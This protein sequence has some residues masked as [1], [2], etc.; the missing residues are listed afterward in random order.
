MTAS[1]TPASDVRTEATAQ[2]SPPHTDATTQPS[3][4]HTDATTQPSPPHTDATTQ[5]A[6]SHTDTTAQPWPPVLVPAD[7]PRRPGAGP[8]LSAVESAPLPGSTVNDTPLDDTPLDGTPPDGTLPDD[9]LLAAAFAALLHRYTGQGLIAVAA[10]DGELRY[11]VDGEHTLADLVAHGTAVDATGTAAA[12]F[13]AGD[14]P[15]EDG[16]PLELQLVIRAGTAQLRYDAELFERDTAARLLGHYLTLLADALAAPGRPV[17]ALR[18]LSD[19]ELHTTLVEWNRTGTEL[20]NS[21]CLHEAFA[22]RAA[23]APDAVAVVHAGR[24]WTYG[25]VNAAANRLAHHLRT[26]GVG[27]DVRVGLCLDRSAELLV[28]ELAILK[29]GG[30]YVP[31]DPDYPAQRIAAMVGGTS[32]AVMI[33]RTDLTGNLPEGDTTPLVL[34]DR[35]TELL[36]ALPEHDPEPVAGPEHLC[37]IIHT[38]GSTGAPKPIALRHRGV[39]NN[40]ADLNTRYD[41]GPGDAVLALSSPSFDMSV[42]EFLGLTVAGGTVVVPDAGRAKDPEHWADLLVA[43]N[44][45]VWNSAPALLNLVTDHLEQTGV[46]VLPRLRLALLGGDWVP[47]TLPERVAAFAPDLRFVVMGGATESSIHSTLYEVEKVDPDWTSIPYGRPMANQRTYILDDHLQPVPPGV[48][49]ELYL[50]GTGLARGYLDQPERTAERFLDWSWGDVVRGE[51]LYRTGDAA[52]FGPDGMI[53]L[54]GR[55]DFQ[56]KIHGL[57]VELGEIET[58]LRS[59]PDV[60]QSVVV[61][62][63][64]RLVGYVVAEDGA[65]ADTDALI[66]L[67]A[68]KLPDYMV[69]AAVVALRKLPLTPNGKLDRL[70]LPEP[71]FTTAEYRAPETAEERVL[72][73]VFAEVLRKERVGVDDDFLVLGGDSIRAIQVVT[74]ARARGL[75]VTAP[76]VLKCRTAARLAEQATGADFAAELVPSAPLA[77]PDSAEFRD[78]RERYPGLADVWPLT[79]LQSGILFESSLSDTGYDVYHMQTV[80]HLSG[81]VDAERMR[82]AGQALLDRYANLRVA[83]VPDADD[84]LVQLVVDGVELPWRELDFSELEGA[85]REQAVTEFLTA[86]Y[87]DHFDRTRP[88]LLRLALLRL[89]ERSYELVLTTHH[90]LIDGWSEPILM[91]DL[92]RL[93]ASGGDASA[94]PA[95]RGFRDFLAWLGRQDREVSARAWGEQLAGLDGPTLLAPG[96][97]RATV[98]GAGELGVALTPAES[99]RLGRRAAELGVT[100][101]TLVQGA[102]AVL[103]GALTG[104]EDVVFGATV[105]GRPG[106]LPGVESMVGLFINTLPVRVRCAPGDTLADLLTG[107]QTRQSALLDHHHHSLAEIHQQTGMDA[108]FDT[109]VAFQSY[110]VDRAGIAGASAAAGIEV[111]GTDA[112]GAANYPLALIVETDPGLRLTLQYHQGVLTEGA[113]D[114]IAGRLHKV[115]RQLL[116]DPTLRVGAVDLLL[117]D[118]RERLGGGSGGGGGGGSRGGEAGLT[119]GAVAVRAEEAP[120]TETVPTQSPTTQSPPT[121]SPAAEPLPLLVER[122]ARQTPDAVAVVSEGVSLSYRELN[123]WANRLAHQLL[124][125]GVGPESVVALAVDRSV[126]LTVAVLGVL[127][128]GAA[129]V[130]AEP[131]DAPVPVAEFVRRSDV[132][133]LGAQPSYPTDNLDP[134]R[135]DR[136]AP[137]RPRDLAWLRRPYV[138][139]GAGAGAGSGTPDVVAVDVVAVDV[140]APG[141]VAVDHRALADGAA[142]FA[143]AAELA[144]GT[145]LL[146]ASPHDDAM[147]FET[148]SALARGACVKVPTE[149]ETFGREWGWTGD[150]IATVAPFFTEVLNRGGRSLYAGT[151]VLTGDTLPEALV[152]RLRELIPGARVVGTYG[153]AET[154]TTLSVPDT[155]ARVRPVGATR[156]YVLDSA[157]RPVPPGVTGELYVGGEAA[158]GYA[159]Q[160]ARTAGRFLPDPFGP[161]GTRMYRTGDLARRSGDGTLEYVGHG[162]PWVRVRGQRVSATEVT[163]ALAAHPEV[164]HAVAVVQEGAGPDDGRLLGYVSPVRGNQVDAEAVRAFVAGRLPDASVPATVVVLG[165][166]PLTPAG[167]VDLAALPEVSTGGSEGGRRGGRTPQEV[168]VCELIADVLG[169]EEVGIDD[170]LFSLGCNSLKATRIIGRMRRT[171]GVEVSIRQLFQHPNVA[172]LSEHLKPATAKSRPSLGGTLRRMTQREGSGT[173]AMA[174]QIRNDTM[175]KVK[176]MRDNAKQETVQ[177]REQ[178]KEQL[179]GQ[180]RDK[181]GA[182][183]HAKLMEDVNDRV[184]TGIQYGAGAGVPKPKDAK[185]AQKLL[186]RMLERFT[187][188][189]RDSGQAHPLTEDDLTKAQDLLTTTAESLG[190]LFRKTPQKTG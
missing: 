68:R 170:D 141:V 105:S 106:A 63:D 70:G 11:E 121:Q 144:P 29:A 40:V 38:S 74:R 16:A 65:T 110:P 5:P 123:T 45:T 89:A 171:L 103:L 113:V 116:Q 17:R 3:P 165:E 164:A 107:L 112:E 6:P 39:L 181:Y 87:A 109:L 18:L 69:P 35:D 36:A 137:L 54:I 15:A 168:A 27:P 64:N 122:W 19:T 66:E 71:E 83:F 20:P 92:L 183:F 129:F 166:L 159:G 175:E 59:H 177:L 178:L 56:V 184:R 55:K 22:S 37:Y 32:C 85:E 167:A 23:L 8:R 51:R 162:G 154:G 180:T 185:E 30:A 157:L 58:V 43:E 125:H 117:T 126:E 10:A 101:N 86:D 186:K 12:G 95:V 60:R 31:L 160:P 145:R 161:D 124:R 158:R 114:A 14:D 174:Q 133:E 78:W 146:A 80:F 48:P 62:R 53:E 28:S 1:R 77:D 91:Q 57:R 156:T 2:P 46:G 138:G 172:E 130:V 108:L 97:P 176:V 188:Q 132:A 163:A 134:V 139:K 79:A 131:G 52:R 93:Y 88:P 100:V 169:V 155:S 7:Q 75:E 61:A 90:V 190:A 115:L 153:P 189:V 34:V 182:D 72:A 67:A 102:W 84:N 120:P 127:K 33:S 143:S 41:V 42:Y 4:P 173:A 82:A 21:G 148:L 44:I 47:V 187:E 147:L 73:A 119:G 96:A 135:R 140:V 151:V 98:R 152:Q 94:L 50:A 136:K 149:I 25:E 118:E 49:G 9:A 128:S 81:A 76:Q 99:R 179:V 104:R 111:T 13:A 26:L 150:V 142:R 24:R